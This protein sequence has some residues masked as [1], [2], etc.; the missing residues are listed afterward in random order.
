MNYPHSNVKKSCLRFHVEVGGGDRKR[1]SQV[2]WKLNSSCSQQP[3]IWILY[4]NHDEKDV[5]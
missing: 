2:D 3:F 1:F 4:V 5:C